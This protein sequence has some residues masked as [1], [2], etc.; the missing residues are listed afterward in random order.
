MDKGLKSK[1]TRRRLLL[2]ACLIPILA[3]W[4][5]LVADVP[6]LFFQG[7]SGYFASPEK[8][9]VTIFGKSDP[10][11]W[12]QYL[13]FDARTGRIRAERN[14]TLARN[15]VS[16]AEFITRFSKDG[17]EYKR[18]RLWKAE[19]SDAHV[20]DFIEF[21]FPAAA[22]PRMV[23]HRYA[24]HVNTGSILV[25]DV[26]SAGAIATAYPIARQ[27]SGTLIPIRD[28]NRFA[29]VHAV[30]L[31]PNTASPQVVV[32]LY[33]I[34]ETGVPSLIRTWP[35]MHGISEPSSLAVIALNDQFI[36]I[37]PTDNNFEIRSTVD[38]SL[39]RTQ[40]LPEDFN[41]GTEKWFLARDALVVYGG[42]RTFWIAQNR[43]L[44]AP[45]GF[46]SYYED[47]PNRR[48]RLWFMGDNETQLVTECDSDKVISTVATSSDIGAFL[49]DETLL[50]SSMH[51]GLTFREVDAKTGLTIRTWRPYWWV[52]PVLWVSV[53]AYVIWAIAWLRSVSES[54]RWVWL[55][56]A[57][58]ISFPIIAL[59]WRHKFVGDTLDLQ[60]DS[61]FIL[62]GIFIALIFLASV[63]GCNAREWVVRKLLPMLLCFASLSMALSLVFSA[64][65]ATATDLLLQASGFMTISIVVCLALRFLGT[66]WSQS[67]SGPE[68]EHEKA[69]L[70]DLFML[71]LLSAAL[72]APMR[73]IVPDPTALD[74]SLIRWK[75]LVLLVF[76]PSIAYAA[77]LI[78]NRNI[79]R[80]G[81]C[82]A[83]LLFLYL[84]FVLP[85]YYYTGIRILRFHNDFE[86][87][88]ITFFSAFVAA[89]VLSKAFR[90]RG[91]RL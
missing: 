26:D 3:A 28:T 64:S 72:F 17:I 42:A 46:L 51:W 55:H 15:G 5:Y 82:L 12:E 6:I 43:W 83:I 39:I 58:V 8:R 21:D 69:S 60:R 20:K 86:G 76:A 18:W 35:A 37:H 62:E 7:T 85:S 34:G 13:V 73:L 9:T 63:W 45:N 74:L 14:A 2:V 29:L 16:W 1:N 65:M 27:S 71:L 68:E 57:W 54:N 4:Y 49:D 31:Q 67:S 41:A 23:G 53:F 87:F 50:F 84:L 80:F 56:I 40:S 59:A 19:A 22:W 88:A 77:A 32:E 33:E 81:K 10:G 38:G 47:S 70:R 89:F 11:D 75:P 91:S 61:F 36:N 44:K 90:Q 24:V 66:H 25:R 79:H 30:P 78:R 52:F 48:L